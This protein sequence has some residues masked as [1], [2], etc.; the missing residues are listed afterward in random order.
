MALT[1]N[2]QLG[3]PEST[4]STDQAGFLILTFSTGHSLQFPLLAQLSTPFITASSPRLYFGVC[5][6]TKFAEGML[7]LSNP[8]DVVAQWS[9]EHVP[10]AVNGPRITNIRVKGFESQGPEV[11]DPSVFEISPTAGS[12]EGPTLSVASTVGAPPKD[13]V[14]ND[15]ETVVPQRLMESSWASSTLN[16]R[17]SVQRRFDNQ[18]NFEADARFPIPVAIQFRPKANSR[19]SSR[20]RFSCDFGNSFDVILTGQGTYEE[21][22][23]KPLNPLPR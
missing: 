15:K 4:K 9:V 3:E 20:F 16:L 18:H 7:L 12:L 21:H 11:D 14:R 10:G 13:I 22:E 19:Y 5:H 1:R 2:Q 6:A 17:D 8:T 23:H